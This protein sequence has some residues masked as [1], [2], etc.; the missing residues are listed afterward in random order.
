MQSTFDIIHAAESAALPDK[1]MITV[2]SQRWDNRPLPWVKELAWQNIKNAGK[3][4]L[5]R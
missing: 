1:I 5:S 4:F 3:R 2:H